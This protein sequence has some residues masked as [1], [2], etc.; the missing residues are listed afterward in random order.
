MKVSYTYSGKHI[1][2]GEEWH[3][4]DI[5]HKSQ[6][7]C[8]AGWPPTIAYLSDIENLTESRPRTIKEENHIR[9]TFGN[10]FL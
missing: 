1:P 8:V 10:R 2:T 7:V 9:K 4:L 6:Q 3:I 5:D